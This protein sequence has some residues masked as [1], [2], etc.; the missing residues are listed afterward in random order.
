MKA[1]VFDKKRV[2]NTQLRVDYYTFLLKELII[3]GKHE[4]RRNDFGSRP[5]TALFFL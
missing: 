3:R 1:R 4:F 5:S 2:H